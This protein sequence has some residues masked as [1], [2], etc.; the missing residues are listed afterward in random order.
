MMSTEGK[1]GGKKTGGRTKGTPNKR[2]QQ[3]QEKLQALGCDP[4]EGLARIG[5]QAERDAREAFSGAVEAIVEDLSAADG[6]DTDRVKDLMGKQLMQA[7]KE[8]RETLSLAV[9]CYGQLRRHWA[10]ELKALEV[11]GPGGDPLEFVG[12]GAARKMAQAVLEA[13]GTG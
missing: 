12:P 7:V 6:I 2:T 11:T 8:R 10:P 9:H 5:M 13:E 4:V 3:V 1:S